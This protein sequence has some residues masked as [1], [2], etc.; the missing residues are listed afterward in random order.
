MDIEQK[1]KGR[2]ASMSGTR[3]MKLCKY[4]K[5]QNLKITL[6]VSAIFKSYNVIKHKN[7]IS[8]LPACKIIL[9]NITPS[10]KLKLIHK[11]SPSCDQLANPLLI[12][13]T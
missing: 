12:R 8:K 11:I 3:S 2:K 9:R 4:V 5:A 13:F 6:F 7:P 1:M 10:Y